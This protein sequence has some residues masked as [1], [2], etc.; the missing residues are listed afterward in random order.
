[1]DDTPAAVTLAS[2]NTAEFFDDGTPPSPFPTPTLTA[3]QLRLALIGAGITLASVEATIGAISDD[4][5]RAV[6]RVEWEYSTQY[7]RD[8]PLIARIGSALGLQPEMIDNL[9]MEAAQL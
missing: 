5:E 6:A 2:I 4:A 9:W 7:R 1:M 3:R 8:H